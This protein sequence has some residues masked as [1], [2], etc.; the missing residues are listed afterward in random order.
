MYSEESY[1]EV[2]LMVFDEG[3]RHREA[4]LRERRPLAERATRVLRLTSGANR[5]ACVWR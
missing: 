3:L 4:A 5:A 1:R 2:R